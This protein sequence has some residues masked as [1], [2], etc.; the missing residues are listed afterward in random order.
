MNSDI[1]DGFL[2]GSGVDPAHLKA[3]LVAI[4]IGVCLVVGMWVINQLI[5]AYQSEDIS[6]AQVMWGSVK[7]MVL[8]GLVFF[9]V[10]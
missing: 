6:A 7:L 4:V 10:I 9:V 3:T 8:L 1:R 2:T 5:Q